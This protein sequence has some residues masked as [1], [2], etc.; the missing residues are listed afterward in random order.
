MNTKSEFGYFSKQVA[1]DLEI[2]TSTLRRW[3]IELEK[4]GYNF[5]RNQKD[6]RIYYE[7]DFKALRELK[8]LLSNNVNMEDALNAV[9]SRFKVGEDT[10]KTHSVHEQELR[11][12]VHDLEELTKEV[13]RK[14]KEEVKQEFEAI[15]QQ[16]QGYIDTKLNRLDERLENRDRKLMESLRLLQEQKQAMLEASASKEK[17]F[18][19][20]F[21]QKKK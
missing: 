9:I 16:Q 20:R 1:T 21:F 4:K 11:L 3:S 2:T 8:T 10:L 5:E 14:A 17:S 19:S 15:I 7:R 13:Y 12:S 6:Q 18:F